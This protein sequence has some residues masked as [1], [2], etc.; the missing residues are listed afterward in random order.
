MVKVNPIWIYMTDSK[1]RNKPNDI[2][3]QKNKKIHN[4]FGHGLASYTSK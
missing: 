3:N 1:V 2:E 4:N